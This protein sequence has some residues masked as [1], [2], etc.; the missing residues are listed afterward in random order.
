MTTSVNDILKEVC[1]IADHAFG[2]KQDELDL[3]ANLLELGLDSLMLLKFG[4]EVE[5]AF[6]VTLEM[7][8][9]FRNLPSLTTLSRHILDSGGKLQ[10]AAPAV[11]AQEEKRKEETVTPVKPVAVIAMTEDP[12]AALFRQQV[13]SMQQVFQKQLAVLKGAGTKTGEV[14]RSPREDDEGRIE[15]NVRG[16]MLG[17]EPGLNSEQERFIDDLMKRHLARTRGSRTHTQKT[18]AALAD[19]KNSLAFRKRLKDVMYPIVAD[20][21]EGAYFVDIDGNR[22]IDIALGMGVNFMGH[23]PPFVV[24]AVQKRLDRGFALGPQCDLTGEAAELVSQVTG[25]E[26]VCF[27]N[28]GSEAVMAGIRIAR[29]VTG[30]RK[31]VLFN[32]SYHGIFD[33]VLGVSDGERVS[34]LSVGTLP[35]MVEDLVFLDYGAEESLAK[36]D[37]IKDELAAVLVEPVQSRKSILQPHVFL[38]K[39]RRLTRESDVPLIF[40]EMVNGFRVGPGGAGEYFGIRPEITLY[41]KII[42]GGLPV[43][44]IAGKAKFLDLIDG[45]WWQYGDD[46]APDPQAIVFGG[47]F[48]RHPL[49]MAAVTA[50]CRYMLKEGPALQRRVNRL[51]DRLADTLNLWFQNEEVPLRI[52]HF[53]SQFK[54]DSYGRYTALANPLELDLFYLLLQC[55]GIYTWE[56]RTCCLSIA[57]SDEDIGQII[58]AVKEAI[59]ELRAGGFSFRQSTGVP[60]WFVPLSSVQKRLYAICQRENGQA[61][62]HMPAAWIVEGELDA[63]WLDICWGELIRRHEA[64]RTGLHLIDGQLVQKIIDEPRFSIERIPHDGKS[65]PEI[66]SDFIRPFDLA[67]QSLLRIGLVKLEEKKHLLLLDTLHLV[68]DGLS[69]PAMTRELKS[70]YERQAL[71]PVASQYRDYV[72]FSLSEDFQSAC[73]KQADWWRG[74]L[75]EK[76]EPLQVPLDWPTAP[77]DYVGG[78]KRLVIDRKM[79][80]DL[81]Q[82]AGKHGLT[83]HMLL[84]ATYGILLSRLT[85]KDKLWVGTAVAGRPGN[86]F[87]ETVGMFV[88][89]LPLLLRPESGMSREEYFAQV[90]MFCA[91]AYEHVDTLYEDLVDIYGGDFVQSLFAYENAD[92]RTLA[93]GDLSLTLQQADITG[94]MFDFSLDTIERSGEIHLDF[95]YATALLEPATVRRWA[96]C[97]K[98]ILRWCLS[99]GKPRLDECSIISE[100]DVKLLEDFGKGVELTLPESATVLTLFDEAV[101]KAPDA[102]AIRFG[103]EQVSYR[104]LKRMSDNLAVSLRKSHGAQPETLFGLCLPPSPR[105]IAA[106]LGILRAGAAYLPFDPAHPKDRLQAV[107]RDA[108]LKAVLVENATAGIFAGVIETVNLQAD[109]SWLKAEQDTGSHPA[110]S[111]DSMAYVIYTSGSTGNP[112]GCELTHRNLLN[113]LLWVRDYYFKNKEYGNFSLTSSLAYDLTVMS[114]F[115]PLVLGKSLR[116]YP[117]ELDIAAMLTDSLSPDSEVDVLNL[118]PSHVRMIAGLGLRE[119]NVAI[120]IVGGEALEQKD[121]NTLISLNSG[122]KIYNEYGPTETTVGCTAGEILPGYAIAIG[123]PIANTSAFVVDRESRLVAPG[124]WGELLIGGAG[125]ARGYRNRPD[126]TA[127]KFTANP[128]GE[129]RVYHTG[130]LARWNSSGALE[131][132]GRIDDQIQLAGYRIEPGE[133]ETALAAHAGVTAAAVMLQKDKLVAFYCGTCPE[134]ELRSHAQSCLPAYMTP[135]LWRKLGELPLAASGKVDRKALAAL[136]LDSAPTEDAPALEDWRDDERQMYNVWK[137]V[138]GHGNISLAEN[139]F[140]AG[141]SSLDAVAVIARCQTELKNPP[142]LRD[143]FAE[144]TIRA[145]CARRSTGGSYGELTVSG[146]REGA[147]QL[148]AGQFEIWLAAQ[149]GSAYNMTESFLL[150]GELDSARLENAFRALVGKHEILRTSFV[151][152]NGVPRQQVRKQGDSACDI[153]ALDLSAENEPL[154]A[155]SALVQ[156]ERAHVFSLENDPLCRIRLVRV[157]QRQ[158]VCIMNI[159]HI[160]ADGWTAALLLSDAVE[161][162]TEPEKIGQPAPFQYRDFCAWHETYLAS[163]RGGKDRAY[164]KN[165]LGGNTA[166]PALPGRKNISDAGRGIGLVPVKFSA[167]TVESC[168]KLARETG[169][170]TYGV[171]LAGLGALL[172]Q[173]S[174]AETICIGTPVAGRVLPALE[175]MPGYFLNTLPLAINAKSEFTFRQMLISAN[176]SLADGLSHQLYPFSRMVEDAAYKATDGRTP[177]FDVMLILQNTARYDLALPGVESKRFLT[178]PATAAKFDFMFELEESVT[179]GIE[180]I[181]EYDSLRYEAAVAGKL[182]SDYLSLLELYAKNPERK[183]SELFSL[184]SGVSASE[185]N[186]FVSTLSDVSDE[187]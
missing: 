129:G 114:V 134:E 111:Q 17:D 6:G 187:F 164:W 56:R 43:G 28:T 133:I 97:Y 51:A 183:L 118:T 94:A 16:F 132:A 117:G 4:Q 173:R 55:K 82:A 146:R 15:H 108:G 76:V 46:S 180:G 123:R 23:R 77:R 45:G 104:D 98:Q 105:A 161:F 18:R 69:L 20:S 91:D 36:I 72:S 89:T 85:G 163:E 37:A 79:T 178:P 127:E 65:V 78:H 11:P 9:F 112:K 99:G 144:P 166:L 159:H 1:V 39:L 63:E 128:H 41:G 52:C 68:L 25:A 100:T 157:A 148:S 3:D 58:A 90:R 93:I 59:A 101:A 83:M 75:A 107:A 47:T 140:S 84:L 184:F 60:Q 64:L 186:A 35:G 135:A 42:G 126:L 87:D 153:E 24:D 74:V 88:N 29:A 48:C 110:V 142:T 167:G 61:P 71:P 95:E 31:I 181:L 162:Y 113:Y 138:L 182:V 21:S 139:F 103:T 122:M 175:Q 147:F 22:Y 13:E 33:G 150:E 141:G 50:T 121:V 170:T 96:D 120:A 53:G 8:W 86:R 30:K 119:T 137:E 44:V 38:K 154:A 10:G 131:I 115:T 158:Y 106:M 156:A 49:S 5:R 92:A 145:L 14:R 185:R 136:Q 32:G 12:V 62:Y 116:I 2:L 27:A 174:N 67:S 130:D 160:I 80:A 149:S 54:F 125:V 171:L 34:P 176:Q 172:F 7:A 57:H 168:L 143:F 165:S 151:V 19:W 40:D 124:I 179:G 169:A 155:A 81:R 152:V 66:V 177:F 109:T 26:R 73:R 102:V 70:L